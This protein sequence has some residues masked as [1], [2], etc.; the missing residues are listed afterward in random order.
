MT[1]DA[2]ETCPFCN[3]DGWYVVTGSAHDPNCDGTCKNCPIPV[4]EQEQ[5]Q[6]CEGRGYLEG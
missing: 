3:G 2:R 6:N 5:W 4:Q 1:T